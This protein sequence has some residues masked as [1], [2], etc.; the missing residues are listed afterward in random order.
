MKAIEHQL[1]IFA[2]RLTRKDKYGMIKMSSIIE[3]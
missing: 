1:G 3:E 2:P